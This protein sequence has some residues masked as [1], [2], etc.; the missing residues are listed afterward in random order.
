MSCME[1]ATWRRTFSG[2]EAVLARTASATLFSP[3]TFVPA[4]WLSR[5]SA[6]GVFSCTGRLGVTE[7]PSEDR[8]DWS[9]GGIGEVPSG[10]MNIATGGCGN[11]AGMGEGEDICGTAAD[12]WGI[13]IGAAGGCGGRTGVAFELPSSV[14]QDGALGEIA[15][16]GGSTDAA[17]GTTGA[18]GVKVCGCI[19]VGCSMTGAA[20]GAT[21]GGVVG[22]L[23]F[24]V[25]SSSFKMPVSQS[26]SS[27][28]ELA[29][30]GC[31][32]GP[33]PILSVLTATVG[34]SG[35]PLSG[36]CGECVCGPLVCEVAS[37]AEEF[38]AC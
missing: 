33:L 36:I 3:V 6:A 19:G 17:G 10:C 32:W 38:C 9:N 21:G 2:S 29:G 28:L 27:P 37:G 14:N 31:D 11:D 35:T 26:G 13:G 5:S 15:G 23:A 16:A 1:R 20:L 8:A 4:I 25:L 18:C 30:A 24:C 7:V 22:L 12:G 34:A